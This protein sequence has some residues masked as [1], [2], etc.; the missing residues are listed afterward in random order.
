MKRTKRSAFH[1]AHPVHHVLAPLALA[2]IFGGIAIILV[3]SRELSP[4]PA[5]PAAHSSSDL[6]KTGTSLRP[7]FSSSTEEML[8]AQPS[9][10]ALI[11]YTDSGFEPDVLVIPLDAT[12][13]F[14]NNTSAPL[15]IA[16]RGDEAVRMYPQAPHGCGP[17]GID[18]CRGLP[19][20]DAWQ[21]TFTV[22]G[23]W[24]IVNALKESHS[25]VIVVQ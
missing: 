4:A 19:S 11:S 2:M 6:V 15:W 21:F 13:R 1:A 16:S 24:R 23:T 14:A 9:F 10:A 7:A 8:R 12:V 5:M 25:V 18:S 17:S 20:Q 3:A 22:P